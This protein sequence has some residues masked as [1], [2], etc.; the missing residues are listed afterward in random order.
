MKRFLLLLIGIAMS[1]AIIGQSDSHLSLEDALIIGM[2]NNYDIRLIRQS[3]QIAVN[4]ATLGNAG[5]LP[6]VDATIVQDFSRQDISATFITEDKLENN[7]AKSNSLTAGAQLTWTLFDGLQMF[8]TYQKLQELSQLGEIDVQVMLENTVSEIITTYYNLIQ[9]HQRIGVWQ[10]SLNLSKERER[11][12]AEKFTLGAGSYREKLVARV[13]VN[14]DSSELLRQLNLLA[15]SKI[16]MNRLLGRE[17]NTAFDI[18]TLI[19]VNAKLEYRQLRDDA[20][21]QNPDL[22]QSRQLRQI[23]VLERKEIQAER[24]PTLDFNLGYSFNR[25]TSEAGFLLSNQVSGLNYGLTAGINLFNGMNLNR[26]IQN[27]EINIAS[28]SLQQESLV[29]QLETSLSQ[30]YRSYQNALRLMNLEKQNLA[31]SR[32]NLDITRQTYELGELSSIEFRETQKNH[33]ESENRWI[34]SLFLVKINEIELMRLSGN[35]LK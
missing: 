11:I 5:F 18:D 16:E 21:A 20:M 30:A 14:A 10:E 1:Q 7:G 3:G 8:T 2:E 17:P 28:S 33:V 15:I 4:N 29:H 24:Y 9:Q 26:R 27:A 13:D 6:R 22:L 23:A 34:E 31:V 12:A 25:S 19:D 35:L 32:E